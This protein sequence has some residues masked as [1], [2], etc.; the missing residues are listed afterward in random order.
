MFL[1]KVKLAAAVLLTLGVLGSGAGMFARSGKAADPAKEGK[2]PEESVAKAPVPKQ[3]EGK[4]A[5]PKEVTPLSGK[6]MREA[7]ASEVNYAGIDLPTAKLEDALNDMTQKYGVRFYVNE[8]AFVEDGVADVLGVEVAQPRPFPRMTAPLTVV[9]GKL[10][11]RLPAGTGAGIL[12]RPG[13]VEI[14]TRAAVHA[15]L[16]V[17]KDRQLLPLVYENVDGWPLETALQALANDSGYNIVLDPQPG[18]A[19]T[20]KLTASL[21]NV[22][23]DTAVRLLA[24]MADMGMV[25]LDNVLYVTTREKAA[26]MQAEQQ[27]HAKPRP[28]PA[29][30][31][32]GAGPATGPASKAGS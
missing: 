32:P 20:P 13:L 7:L 17:S 21:H 31:K 29:E 18:A 28:K 3:P 19:K 1:T 27:P 8:K 16:G 4:I 26:R 23:V 12:Y 30:V 2:A 11:D 6:A 14:T 24:D 9:L 22:P 10:L 25:R 15:E 5:I